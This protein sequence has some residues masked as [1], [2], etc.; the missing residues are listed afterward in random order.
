MNQGRADQRSE[1][2][3]AWSRRSPREWVWS[4]RRRFNPAGHYRVPFDVD[5]RMEICLEDE[6]SINYAIGANSSRKSGRSSDGS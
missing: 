4:V 3:R 2:L 6:Q 1:R 5:L